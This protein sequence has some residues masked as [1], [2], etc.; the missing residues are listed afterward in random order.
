MDCLHS[1]SRLNVGSSEHFLLTLQQQFMKVGSV[2]FAQQIEKLMEI[3]SGTA[4]LY[5]QGDVL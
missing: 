2:H 3:Y 5:E 1:T 4:L